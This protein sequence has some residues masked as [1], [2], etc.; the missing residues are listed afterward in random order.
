M[1][2]KTED[3]GPTRSP[4]GWI[5]ARFRPLSG[6][7][8]VAGALLMAAALTPSLVPRS[9]VL[10]GVLCGMSLALGYGL[11]GLMRMV[12]QALEL[13][14][15]SDRVQQLLLLGAGLLAAGLVLAS[16][17]VSLAWQNAIR[18][19]MG[20]APEQ[21]G[22]L[23]AVLAIALGVATLLLLLSRLFLTLAHL[24]EGRAGRFL[25]RPLAWVAGLAIAAL[26]FWSI[27][28][29][30]LVSRML[31]IMDAAYAK[32]D[33]TIQT[34]LSPP[35]DPAKTGSSASLIGWQ[36]IGHE[37]RN[38]VAG[39]P[40]AA[41]IAAL[42]GRAAKEPI[43]V[44]VGLNSAPD[45]KAAAE[46]ALA[47]LRRVG[48]FERELLVIATPTGTG[49]LDQAGLAPL[50]ILQG[51]DVATVTVQYSYLP[52]WLS[53]LVAPEYGKVT[54]RVV[55]QAVYGH[56]SSLPPD[57]RPRLFLFGLSLG[58]LN[59]MISTDL[60]AVIDDPFDGALWVGPP[61]ASRV[62][63]DAVASRD[64][65][66][67]VWRPVIHEGRTLRFAYRG[68][69]FLG[70]DEAAQSWGPLRIGILQ[71]S[72]DPITFFDPASLLRAPEWL[73][74]PRAPDL[75][76]GLR[77]YPFVTTLQG[78]LDVVT[79][80]QTPVGHG[81]VYAGSD[82]LR[83]WADLTAPAGWTPDGINGIAAALRDRGL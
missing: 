59:S 69:G 61:F 20:L 6:L 37:G 65:E 45:A 14:R 67:P 10:Q 76:P 5:A 81:H 21:S 34:D 68:T 70:P 31:T 46:L 57:Q 51:G 4:A 9:P 79:A 18:Q 32:I 38:A 42:S 30:V 24:V 55:F 27:G 72:G 49:W 43:R 16:L 23:L 64:P 56:W 2:A 17:W 1:D 82:Y 54:A 33:S 35:D 26:V 47:E 41:D 25:S 28:N 39:W 78:L 74:D 12:W 36:G 40:S 62:W 8:L 13:P 48:A 66:S 3:V 52:S 71:Y 63:R 29:G 75:P 80:T 11:G 60:L 77:W 19:S 7:G 53:L 44:Y 15:V 58:A 22:R 50:E 73:G 83:A